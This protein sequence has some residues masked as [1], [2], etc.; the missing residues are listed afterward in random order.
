[1]FLRLGC[2][3]PD[4]CELRYLWAFSYVFAGRV[5]VGRTTS[6]FPAVSPVDLDLSGSSRGCPVEFEDEAHGVDPAPA[7]LSISLAPSVQDV[8]PP[9]EGAPSLEQQNFRR[10]V[11]TTAKSAFAAAPGTV[12]SHPTCHRSEDH[13]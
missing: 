2:V 12:R 6:R 8:L 7:D 9:A 11:F 4:S 3:F 5:C 10:E 1:M 13:G